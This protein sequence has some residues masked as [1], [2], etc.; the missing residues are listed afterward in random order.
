MKPMI[1][2]SPFSKLRRFRRWLFYREIPV[3][4]GMVATTIWVPRLQ[5]YQAPEYI[6]SGQVLRDSNGDWEPYTEIAIQ[7]RDSKGRLIG[8]SAE[9]PVTPK[10]G[11]SEPFWIDDQSIVRSDP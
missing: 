9:G 6:Y 7:A 11:W 10:R 1:W 4:V 2:G 5:R 8:L 3:R